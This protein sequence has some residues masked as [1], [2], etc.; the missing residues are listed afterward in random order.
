MRDLQKIVAWGCA[1][2][3]VVSGVTALLL[4]N[5]ERRAFSAET[6]KQAFDKQGLYVR[7]PAIMAETIYTSITQDASSDPFLKVLT[8]TDWE[9]SIASILPPDELKFI[10][11]NALDSAFSY[12]N[13]ETDS[14]PISLIL[15]KA[16]IAGPQGMETVLRILSAQ[17]DCTLEQLM[18]MG[19]GFLSGELTLCKPPEEMMGLVT[20]LIE[21]QLQ[22][23]TRS[24]PDEVILIS[25][26]KSDVVNDPRIHLN[27]IRTIMKWSPIFPLIFLIGVT[28]F[29]VRNLSDWLKWWGYPFFVTGVAGMFFAL[30][31]SPIL[32]LVI[33]GTMQQQAGNLLPPILIPLLGET[34]SAVARQI[35]QPVII[36][37]LILGI[38]GSGMVFTEYLLKKVTLK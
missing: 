23:I 37:G 21:T 34:V 5:I 10:S 22:A 32:G 2:L 29:A 13:N 6:Y 35:L 14:A 28:V 9:A 36:E 20:P 33:Q 26:E 8:R 12:L 15:L 27:I 24:I 25:S 11:N 38:L 30:I 16:R 17:P 1:F 18:Q 19:T 3:I 4:F 31:G 7:M